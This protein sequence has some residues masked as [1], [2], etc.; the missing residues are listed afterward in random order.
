[1]L[2]SG[3]VGWPRLLWGGLLPHLD[4]ARIPWLRKE[5]L[6]LRASVFLILFLSLGLW[7]LIGVGIAELVKG[8]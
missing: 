4:E 5:K 8:L 1:M 3:S 7:A 2:I 6:S